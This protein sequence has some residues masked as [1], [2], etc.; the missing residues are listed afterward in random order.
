MLP[1]LLALLLAGAFDQRLA[2]QAQVGRA[3]S[4]S[5]GFEVSGGRPG[6]LTDGKDHAVCLCGRACIDLGDRSLLGF[7]LHQSRQLIALLFEGRDLFGLEATW[8]NAPCFPRLELPIHAP[9][10]VR[11]L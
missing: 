2:L 1:L 9:Q 8:V 6:C 4:A 7:L 10:G 11:E 5:D 3:A